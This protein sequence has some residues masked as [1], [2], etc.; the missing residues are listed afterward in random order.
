MTGGYPGGLRVLPYWPGEYAGDGE[1]YA[2][3][4]LSFRMHERP[5]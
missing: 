2:D 1:G 5:H 3:P 4:G